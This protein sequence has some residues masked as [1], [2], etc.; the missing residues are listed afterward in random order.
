MSKTYNYIRFD[1]K[2]LNTFLDIIDVEKNGRISLGDV[3]ATCRNLG[4]EDSYPSI[5]SILK[6]MISVDKGAL[7]VEDV[8]QRLLKNRRTEEE[9]MTDIFNYFD[10]DHK[11]E[12]NKNKLK[13]I[14]HELTGENLPDK[15]AEDMIKLLQNESGVVDLESFMQI[16]DLKVDI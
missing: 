16:I 9:E 5:K 7:L 11:G 3:E 10:Y 8:R 2:E 4:L 15:E 12:I 6:D 13:I 14:V 1:E